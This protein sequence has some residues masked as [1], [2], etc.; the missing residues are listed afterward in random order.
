MAEATRTDEG[1]MA[2]TAKTVSVNVKLHEDVVDTARIVAGYKKVQ[3]NDLLSDI[4][5]PILATME[6]EEVAKRKGEAAG[7]AKGKSGR[8]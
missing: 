2:K 8:P 6:A 7:P 1:A 3:I 5:R 4:L